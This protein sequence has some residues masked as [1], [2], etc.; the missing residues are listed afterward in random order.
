ME[1]LI[2][3]LSAL[4][5][6]FPSANQSETQTHI[7]TEISPAISGLWQLELEK[8]INGCTERYNFAADG[9]LTVVSGA[10]WTQGKYRVVY[11]GDDILPMLIMKTSY[12]NNETD[13]SGNKI[14]QS[15]E[16]FG[17]FLQYRADKPSVMQ[18]CLDR[19]GKSCF[20]TFNRILP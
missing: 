14:D 3:T 9:K 2:L 7:T 18:L 16:Q 4:L 10:E 11:S 1:S 15:G 12:D 19:Q 6:T 8:P 17:A 5:A 13:C 20:M